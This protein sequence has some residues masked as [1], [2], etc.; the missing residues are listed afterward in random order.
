MKAI[1]FFFTVF[2]SVHS[3]VYAQKAEVYQHKDKFG[4]KQGDKTLV[5]PQYEA[6]ESLDEIFFAFK[7]KGKCG[8]IT[9]NGTIVVPQEYD[10]IKS[11]GNGLFLVKANDAWG[12]VDRINQLVLPIK[13]TGFKF[14]NP[15]LCEVKSEGKCGFISKYG[16]IVV[17]AQYEAVTPFNDT[18]FL[19]KKD[20]KSGLIDGSGKVVLEAKYDNFDLIPGKDLYSLKIG[21]KIGLMTPQ[22]EVLLSP[23]Y[24]NIEDDTCIG[25]KLTDNGKIG[26]Y[27]K[28]N[29]V[30]AP[31][32][33]KILFYQPEL[34]LAVIEQSGKY[35]IITSNGTVTPCVYEN[36]SRF[37]PSGVAFVE[38]SGKLMAINIEGRELLL[39]EIMGAGN[40]P[41]L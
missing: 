11:F 36:I 25:M 26:F 5:K 35:G 17:P 2:L 3:V 9:K 21:N 1:A 23:L 24:D 31:A 40:T 14:I 32:Y 27:T 39:Q 30:I 8:V 34:G 10:D 12:L 28:T 41:P 7:K 37:S 33:T 20:G 29:Q 4:I 38:K 22:G 16:E 13:Y 18:F 19:I 15:D 6:M